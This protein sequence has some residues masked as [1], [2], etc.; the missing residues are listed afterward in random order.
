MKPAH[1]VE[2]TEFY[3]WQDNLTSKDDLSSD[4]VPDE[5]YDFADLIQTFKKVLLREYLIFYRYTQACY[6]NRSTDG[7][8]QTDL[9][10]PKIKMD[11]DRQMNGQKAKYFLCHFIQVHLNDVIVTK[12]MFMSLIPGP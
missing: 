10:R 12:V 8:G 4:S 11:I 3:P 1:Q 5:I 2:V 7:Q 9:E 6:I